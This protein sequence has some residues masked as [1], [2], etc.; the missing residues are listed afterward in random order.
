MRAQYIT[1]PVAVTTPPVAGAAQEVDHLRNKT[2]QFSGTFVATLQ[3]EGSLD[4]TNWVAVESAVT[5]A[6]LVEVSHTL[7]QLRVK[8]T[9]YTSGTPVA[10]LVGLDARTV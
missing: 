3:L 5:A 4:G 8:T 10:V 7:K 9:A 1:L 2:V 6:G